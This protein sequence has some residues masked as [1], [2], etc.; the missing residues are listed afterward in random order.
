MA[1][2]TKINLASYLKS[3]KEEK[4]RLK[5]LNKRKAQQATE[6]LDEA[7]LAVGTTWSLNIKAIKETCPVGETVSRVLAF[8]SPRCIPKVV[9]NSGQPRLRNEELAESLEDEIEIADIID[10]LTR[11]SLFLETSEDTVQ[12]HRLVQ[13]IIQDQVKEEGALLETLVIAQSLLSGALNL[14]A[15][16]PSDVIAGSDILLDATGLQSWSLLME[17]V[18]HYI[19]Q[20]RLKEHLHDGTFSNMEFVTLLN[21]ATLYYYILNQFQRAKA[22]EQVTFDHL[23]KAS[24]GI[25][26]LQFRI[27]IAETEK[28]LLSSLM[29]TRSKVVAVT[30]EK[31][32]N[33]EEEFNRAEQLKN[34]GILCLAEEKYDQAVSTFYRGLK[35][36]T[37][38]PELQKDIMINMG[39]ALAKMDS[40][41]AVD[42]CIDLGETMLSQDDTD[43]FAMLLLSVSYQKKAML[44]KDLE[45]S[46]EEIALWQS[47]SVLMAFLSTRYDCKTPEV[48]EMQGIIKDSR[49]LDAIGPV[50]LIQASSNEE[51]L[52]D[53]NATS[54]TEALLVVILNPTTGGQDYDL[55]QDMF[56]ALIE[57]RNRP[58]TLIAGG[59]QQSRPTVWHPKKHVITSSSNFLFYNVNLRLHEGGAG[60]TILCPGWAHVNALFYKTKITSPNPQLGQIGWGLHVQGEGAKVCLVDCEIEGPF[61]EGISMV[62]VDQNGVSAYLKRTKVHSCEM[63]FVCKNIVAH[64][65]EVELCNNG[66][67]FETSG[68]TGR[69]TLNRCNIHH[70]SNHGIVDNRQ[71]RPDDQN[72]ET[73]FREQKITVQNSSIHHN[74]TGFWSA[75]SLASVNLMSNTIFCNEQSGIELRRHQTGSAILSE[76]NIFEN[77]HAGILSVASNNVVLFDNRIHDHTGPGFSHVPVNALYHD[78]DAAPDGRPILRDNDFYNNDMEYPSLYEVP[79]KTKNYSKCHVCNHDP[80][81]MA[82][83]KCQKV[84]YCSENCL[85][86][87]LT[88]H[89]D[90]CDFF[91]SRN[92]CPVTVCLPPQSDCQKRNLLM[93]L[94][95]ETGN[96]FFAIALCHPHY[97]NNEE[98]AARNEIRVSTSPTI[99][100]FDG[101]VA[102][103]GKAHVNLEGEEANHLKM[104]VNQFGRIVDGLKCIMMYGRVVKSTDPSPENSL[105][106]EFLIDRFFHEW[107]EDQKCTTCLTNAKK[108]KRPL[109][110]C[111]DCMNSLYADSKMK[112][113][114]RAKEL[115]KHILDPLSVLYS[116]VSV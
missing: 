64:A 49:M 5:T 6:D 4:K 48:L 76:N 15:N 77:Y 107:P 68:E 79:S 42:D 28:E 30:E 75:E 39:R 112:V 86:L 82:C 92:T 55:T 102:I 22:Y 65:E 31:E 78:I 94:K 2:K 62:S 24:E 60:L 80:Q 23:A 14:I 35:H 26:D 1:P 90:F 105:K 81:R 20:L 74:L 97:Q 17:N 61:G 85:K 111:D 47:M 21:H 84:L 12:V 11:L 3:I 89:K 95:I 100:I 67:G 16:T 8:L 52:E 69:I 58:M 57:Q 66:V 115:H 7:R 56:K 70:N 40:R 116:K 101:E 99:T 108:P 113:E 71:I 106:I 73:P 96:I 46:Q 44:V 25:M 87:D 83:Q 34:A 10:T 53:I 59:S 114:E 63:G 38:N 27:P 93:K 91:C 18:G 54:G 43:P 109:P 37:S 51:L 19:E 103:P 41:A 29:M 98:T 36:A 50:T 13:D 33:T 32:S 9:I 72:K 88:G 45:G 110:K 104:I